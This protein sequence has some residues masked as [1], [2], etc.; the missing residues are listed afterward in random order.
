MLDTLDRF[1][2][3]LT[4]LRLPRWL[5]AFLLGLVMVAR[6]MSADHVHVRAASLAYWSLVALVP[7]LVLAAVVLQALGMTATPIRD[8]MFQ[9]LL[10]G[11]VSEVGDTLDQIVENL[12][13]RGLGIAGLLGVLWTGSRIFFQAEDAYNH[14]W[15]VEV[16]RPVLGRLLLFYAGVTLGPLVLAYGFHLGDSVSLNRGFITRLSPLFLSTGAFVAA[17]RLLPDAKVAW[18]PAVVGGLLSGLLFEGAKMAFNAYTSLLHTEDTNAAIYGSLALAPI[19]L[20]WLYILWLIVLVGVELAY[21]VQHWQE[22]RMV[23]EERIGNKRSRY[24]D[25]WMALQC[26]WV[27]AQRFSSGEGPVP[28]GVVAQTLKV[29]SLLVGPVL[30]VLSEAGLTVRTETGWMLALPPEQLPLRT[31]VERYR[32]LTLSSMDGLPLESQYQRWM[33][34][35]EM[36][37]SLG[38]VLA[39]GSLPP[40]A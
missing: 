20:L 19:F 38:D 27:V 16:R 32:G 22:L 37:Q 9:T 13:F 4:L 24:P 26:M 25:A 40:P 18:R 36:E 1:Y 34:S 30:A 33:H 17:I 28:E 39:A 31:V 23:T 35:P 21:V 15:G 14:L 11:A 12:D 5:H 7:V 29:D 3:R 2:R 10:A 6:K 8:V